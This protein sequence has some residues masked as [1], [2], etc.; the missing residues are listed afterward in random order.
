MRSS[1]KRHRL[2]FLLVLTAF[3]LSSIVGSSKPS[4]GPATVKYAI[5]SSR[6]K[7][8]ARAFAGGLLWFKG[9]DHHLVAKEFSGDVEVTPDSITPASLH[10]V[11]KA[12]SLV[13]TGEAFT[14]P[15][16]EIINKELREIVFHPD[17][18]PDITFQSTSVT[19]KPSNAGGHEVKIMGNLTLHGTTRPVSIPAHLTSQG[20]DLHATGEFTVDRGNFGVK[21]TSAFHGMV[22]VREDVKIMFDIVAHR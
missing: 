14:P 22:R 21:A 2:I 6:S 12:D 19:A 17:R 18:Y 1:E 13:E 16:K 8:M 15:Q 10:F 7:F 4:S 9:H 20:N 5:D 11:V 3:G